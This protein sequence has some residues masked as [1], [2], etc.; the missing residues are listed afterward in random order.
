M[1]DAEMIQSVET[2]QFPIL[3]MASLAASADI[4]KYPQFKAYVLK[5]FG[6]EAEPFLQ[7]YLM[8]CFK[9]EDR[10]ISECMVALLNVYRTMR[11]AIVYE[12]AKREVKLYFSDN[13]QDAL[14]KLID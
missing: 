12:G 8:R 3:Q 2:A 5:Y 14:G 11:N 7:N 4:E 10:K 1:N 6:I 13:Y 9:R